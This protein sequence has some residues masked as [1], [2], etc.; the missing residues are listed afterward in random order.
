MIPG[1]GRGPI[2]DR[3][4]LAFFGINL[5]VS[6]QMGGINDALNPRN[7]FQP[8]L[9]MTGIIANKVDKESSLEKHGEWVCMFFTNAKFACLLVVLARRPVGNFLLILLALGLAKPSLA[10]L[11]LYC[12][13]PGL[14]S[15]GDAMRQ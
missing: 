7:L 4:G 3:Q 6:V 15:T 8:P 5:T 13:P 1:G 12:R 10:I 14:R 9:T 2:G 11:R